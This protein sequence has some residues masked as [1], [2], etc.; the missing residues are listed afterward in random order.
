MLL[1]RVPVSSS[2]CPYVCP[3]ICSFVRPSVRPCLRA[4]A[5]DHHLSSIVPRSSSSLCSLMPRSVDADAVAA[6]A[7]APAPDRAPS[8]MPVTAPLLGA[9]PPHS[10]AAAVTAAAG[11]DG[12]C[13]CAQVLCGGSDGVMG[14][15][16]CDRCRFGV[17]WAS[18]VS[19]GC[20]P[21][22]PTNHQPC[23]TGAGV[24]AAVRAVV[25]AAVRAVL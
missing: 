3:H 2:V 12:G 20:R 18:R 1:V 24:R 5:R 7:P 25:R 19:R 8:A 11:D 23:S 13:C 17:A 14:L 16:Q 9:A 10:A 15:S 6:P 21:H 4:H 22:I